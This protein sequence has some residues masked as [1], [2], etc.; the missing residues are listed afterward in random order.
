M[1]RSAVPQPRT[2][3]LPGRHR[4]FRPDGVN[5][6][7]DTYVTKNDAAWLNQAADE[8]NSV[9]QES[10]TKARADG[11]DAHFVSPTTDKDGFRAHGV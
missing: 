11:I 6:P 9:L 10:V 8:L 7:V 5:V 1:S 4:T 3:R 2:A